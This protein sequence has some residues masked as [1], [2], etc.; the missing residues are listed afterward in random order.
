MFSQGANPEICGDETK[1]DTRLFCGCPSTRFTVVA[2]GG[3]SRSSY[4]PINQSDPLIATITAFLN[5]MARPT[6][7]R[8]RAPARTSQ[9][10]A[11]RVGQGVNGRARPDSRGCSSRGSKQGQAGPEAVRKRTFGLD[12]AKGRRPI[13]RNMSAE[14]HICLAIG[15]YFVLIGCGRLPVPTW[16]ISGWFDAGGRERFAIASPFH[17]GRHRRVVAGTEH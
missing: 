1:S 4:W 13:V 11:R 6:E 15:A 12:A 5:R 17:A 3:P 2:A 7:L 10:T 8:S 16:G 14:G 9:E